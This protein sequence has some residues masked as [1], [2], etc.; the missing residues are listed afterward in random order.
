MVRIIAALAVAGGSFAL[1]QLPSAHPSLAAQLAFKSD[2]LEMPSASAVRSYLSPHLDGRPVAFCLVGV[3]VCGK[4]AADAFCRGNG[5]A[6]AITF[7]RDGAASDPALLHF[8]QIKCRRAA[9]A[10]EQDVVIELG[11]A[12][13]E[14]SGTSNLAGKSDRL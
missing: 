2:R 1:V 11:G 4:Q 10:L 3:E 12:S 5:F 7:E 14:S 8:R 13:A 9:A 6:E